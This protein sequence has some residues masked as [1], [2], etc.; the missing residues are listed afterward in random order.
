MT[1]NR[2]TGWLLLLLLSA[3]WGT[4]YIL[5]K[6]SLHAFSPIQIAALRVAT[7][8]LVLL[9]FAIRFL[10][11]LKRKQ[12][13]VLMGLGV[14]GNGIPA[15]LFAYAQTSLDS[16]IIGILNSLA[17]LFTLIVAVLFFR[18]KTKLINVMGVVLGLCAAIGLIYAGS[19]G[20][21]LKNLGYGSLI[22]FATLLYSINSNILKKMLDDI[23]PLAVT[24]LTLFGVGLA[25][26]VVL[27]STD[28]IVRMET[29]EGAWECL[30]YSSTLGIVG[31]S[32]A[33][34]L[35]NRMLKD[36]TA[37]FASTV[38]YLIPIFALMWGF[39]DGERLNALQMI[40][41]A[42]VLGAVAL[43]NFKRKENL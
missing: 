24:S 18:F 1:K 34:I 13:W 39:L 22:I 11:Q 42:M 40:M 31:T 37:L 3:V 14:L 28:F 7:A 2:I 12:I 9:P 27:F 16:G 26:F 33:M 23:R 10:F 6:K 5:M 41:A 20:F 29:V 25:G 36:N 21:F 4:S 35:Y 8:S 15:F 38:T 19:S 43:V 30:G 32:V 17:P